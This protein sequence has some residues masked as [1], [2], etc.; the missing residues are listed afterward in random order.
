[1]SKLYE[2]ILF[3]NERIEISEEQ[4]EQIKGLADKDTSF[5]VENAWFKSSAIMAILPSKKNHPKFTAWQNFLGSSGSRVSFETYLDQINYPR[6]TD[7][8]LS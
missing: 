6:N 5:E 3:G 8:L 7:N 2:V 4:A 1:M